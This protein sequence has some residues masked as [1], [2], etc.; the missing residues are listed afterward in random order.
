MMVERNIEMP[1]NSGQVRRVKAPEAAGEPHR[2]LKRKRGRGDAVRRTARMEHPLV[3]RRVM[4]DE[5]F[6]PADHLLELRP[7]FSEGR[8]P[9]H[10]LPGT[11]VEIGKIEILPRGFDEKRFFFDDHP[12]F[13][14]DKPYGAGA[15]GSK[16]GSLKIDRDKSHILMTPQHARPETHLLVHHLPLSV[17]TFLNNEVE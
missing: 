6:R 14:R 8:L 7:Q 4:G 5:K 13:D 12:L 16:I 15:I 10:I 1:A 3:E 2:T 11:P 9:F 17:R